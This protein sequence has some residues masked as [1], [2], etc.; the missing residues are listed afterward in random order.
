MAIVLYSGAFVHVNP[1]RRIKDATYRQRAKT[2]RD[3][4]LLD[5]DLRS[6]LI[7]QNKTLIT[8]L[9]QRHENVA[10]NLNEYKTVIVSPATADLIDVDKLR[11][12]TASGKIKLF[13][14]A[15]PSSKVR[16]KHK[17]IVISSPMF[18]ETIYQGGPDL[19]DVAEHLFETKQPHEYVMVRI[20]NLAPFSK[21]FTSMRTFVNYITKWQPKE[22]VEMRE[23]LIEQMSVIR[24]SG[25]V[26]EVIADASTDPRRQRMSKQRGKKWQKREGKF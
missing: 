5:I 15:G 17:K 16:V 22:D 13:I 18:E 4:G 11:V 9:W 25:D 10:R 14:H 2:L 12:E 3:M 1:K 24:M 26:T 19:F 6:K 8:K 21:I 20:G 23:D 7:P